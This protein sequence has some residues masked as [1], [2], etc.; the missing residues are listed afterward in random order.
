M[1][2]DPILSFAIGIQQNPHY[3]NQIKSVAHFVV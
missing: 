3:L 1:F 2:P